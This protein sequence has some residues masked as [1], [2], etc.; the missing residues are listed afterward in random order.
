MRKNTRQG[1]LHG[2]LILLA[3]MAIIKVIGAFFKIELTN[4]IGGTGM[5]YFSCAFGLFSPIFALT[6][7]AVPLVLSKM[8]A[9]FSAKGEYRTVRR[10]RR[11][12][13]AVF[14]I[15]GVLGSIAVVVFAKPFV[16]LAVDSPSAY[17][18]VVAIAP[19]ILFCCL[20]SVYRGYYEGLCNMYPTAL[21][22]IVE[23]LAR[24]VCGLAFAYAALKIGMG[25]YESMGM[26]F[27]QEAATFAQATMLSLPYAA[28]AAILGVTVSCLCGLLY[29]M[30]RY[31]FS[32][33]GITREQL[34]QSAAPK[35]KRSLLTEMVRLA[36]PVAI[37]AIVANLTSIIDLM[38]I[39]KL[40]AA[41]IERLPSYFVQNFGYALQGEIGLAELPNFIYGSYTGLA[42]TIFNFVPAITA[43]FGKSA[44][45]GLMAAWA[46]GNKRAVVSS[47]HTVLKATM[48]LAIPAGI[49][50]FVM[51]KPILEL[52]YA[53]RTAE[54]AVAY[55]SL[56]FMGLGV[57]VMSLLGTVINLLQAIDKVGLTVKLMAFGTVFKLIGNLALV[58]IP[59]LNIL[60][61]CIAT[62]G[63]FTVMLILGLVALCRTTGVR[64]S[65][66]KVLMKPL[67]AG[68]VCG[69]AAAVS[70][71]LANVISATR[72]NTIWAAVIGAAVYCVVL[73]CIGGIDKTD[74][75]RFW[76]KL[77]PV[78]PVKHDKKGIL[79]EE[80]QKNT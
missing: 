14:F 80:K 58:G 33:D 1:F 39:I 62:V 25:Q 36:V 17:L 16:N 13:L 55:P 22:Q 53:R 65:V 69:I 77:R 73:F 45:P 47:V 4:I 52:L 59:E 2:S 7:A 38:T 8:V 31:R 48:L 32:G 57:I 46:V 54:I 40:I 66:G 70:Y 12:A 15:M 61:A 21:S 9:E 42:L 68:I 24:A 26:V 67:I 23:T 6:A 76:R 75:K 11:L 28:A 63:S 43:M 29:L 79:G 49:G 78:F 72:L 50:I 20:I 19:S 41:S 56:A 27:G 71:N 51:A 34:R 74:L 60:G 5:G 10:L 37:G 64:F 3:S 44:L 18:S 35:R 30:A